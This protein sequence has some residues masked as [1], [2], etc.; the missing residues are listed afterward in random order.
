MKIYLKIIITCFIISSVFGLLSCNSKTSQDTLTQDTLSNIEEKNEEQTT[1]VD[2]NKLK[3]VKAIFYNF[4]SPIEMAQL[5]QNA[6]APYNSELMNSVTNVDNY[7]KT[8]SLALNLGV[9][10]ADLSYNRLYDQIQHSINYLATIRK[11]TEQLKI[12]QDEGTYTVSRIEENI[13]DKDTLFQII[14]DTYTHADIYLKE[15]NRESTAILIIVGGWVEALY[16]ATNILDKNNPNQEIMYCIAEQKFSLI[17]LI[18]IIDKCENDTEI[19][20]IIKTK[21]LKLKKVFDKIEIIYQKGTIKT[22]SINNKTFVNCIT[23][24]EVDYNTINDI[25]IIIED[26]RNNIVR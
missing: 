26:L 13:E 4:P 2:S 12:P 20:G 6:N 14:S 15:N 21:L 24:I 25:R 5:L 7:S 23:E 9:Y 1:T 8:E 22:D 18:K 17:N 16:I 11:I 19:I 10:G 3:N